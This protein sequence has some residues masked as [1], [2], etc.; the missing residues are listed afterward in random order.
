M[1]KNLWPAAAEPAV[2]YEP[3]QKHEVIPGIPPVG[4]LIRSSWSGVMFNPI[5]SLD[6]D[7]RNTDG[8]IRWVGY[9]SIFSRGDVTIAATMG[10]Q[11]PSP[12]FENGN[13]DF[14]TKLE[15]FKQHGVEIL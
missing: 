2:A 6:P 15:N 11:Q 10:Q 12:S 13:T 1:N 8:Q 7:Q 4:D 14:K 5:L 9:D 3:V